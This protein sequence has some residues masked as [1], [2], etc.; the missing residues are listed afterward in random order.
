MPVAREPRQFDRRV[1]HTFDP[2]KLEQ[3]DQRTH[4]VETVEGQLQRANRYNQIRQDYVLRKTMAI[5]RDANKQGIKLHP[6]DMKEL[7]ERVNRIADKVFENKLVRAR[8]LG[9]RDKLTKLYLEPKFK[10]MVEDYI[11]ENEE[12]TFIFIDLND[13]KTVNDSKGHNIGDLYIKTFSEALTEIATR[14]KIN[15]SRKNAGGDE[16]LMYATRDIPIKDIT[17]IMTELMRKFKQEWFK[18]HSI[19][20]AEFAFGVSKKRDVEHIDS[21]SEKY[22]AL[23][24]IADDDMYDRKE[25]MKS[26][27]R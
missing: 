17:K 26:R 9:E 11:R 4:P 25:K 23:K 14:L 12:G 3:L 1:R 7:I 8:D 16:F 24:E 2:K 13:L 5:V 27:R 19:G 22:T 6:E 20:N 15:I 21:P 18:K 10:S